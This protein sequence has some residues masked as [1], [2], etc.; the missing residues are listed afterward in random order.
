MIS[1][2][3]VYLPEPAD[4]FLVLWSGT[5]SGT[6]LRSSLVEQRRLDP[7]PCKHPGTVVHVCAGVPAVSGCESLYNRNICLWRRR[8]RSSDGKHHA[9]RCQSD[10][11]GTDL[12]SILCCE[13]VRICLYIKE[14]KSTEE[15]PMER[16]D[17]RGYERLSG[18]YGESKIKKT[19]RKDP[20]QVR[21]KLYGI[22][23]L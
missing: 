5:A 13:C 10:S 3:P 7:E 23:L 6:D 8:Y 12:G 16:R 22:F 20:V 9:D 1:E 18:G 17:L 2:L 21:I 19:Y 4:P 14:S 15:E 11:T